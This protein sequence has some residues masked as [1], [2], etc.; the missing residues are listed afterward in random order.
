[1]LSATGLAC[2]RGERHL[3]GGLDFDLPAGDWLHVKGDNGA[4]KTTLL[5]TL[6]GL[7]RPDAGVVR[8]RDKPVQAQ[9]PAFR[10]ATVYVGHAA[11]LKDDLD[12][13]ENLRAMLEIDGVRAA[14]EAI[15]GALARMGLADRQEI[16][17]RQLSAGQRRRVLL[18]RLLLRP[19]EVWV[20]DEPFNAL[21]TAGVQQLTALVGDHL[22]A[23][24]VAVIT[25]HQPVPLDHGQEVVL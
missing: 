22:R 8:W 10:A 18:A 15:A 4:G 2:S 16:P 17:V 3:F 6:L 12:A 21:D 19:A 5:R 7:S 13:A 14:P 25:S 20:L 1:M 23:G 9:W 11:A 24:G